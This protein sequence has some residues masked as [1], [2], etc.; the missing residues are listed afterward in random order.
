M[1]P[2]IMAVTPRPSSPGPRYLPMSRGKTS[3]NVWC[4]MFARGSLSGTRTSGEPSVL[5]K[6]ARPSSPGMVTMIGTSIL[7]TAPMIYRQEQDGGNGPDQVGMRGEHPV[8]VGHRRPAHRLQRAEI[9][10]N[11][12]QPGNPGRHLAARH[13]EVL[14]G[15]DIL[16][17]V[18]PD[19]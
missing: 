13:E 9:G 3:L 6:T 11:E 4:V 12:A 18:D 15:T 5:S 7:S 2:A 1:K 19:P 10:R 17:Q 14:T 8:L 16:L